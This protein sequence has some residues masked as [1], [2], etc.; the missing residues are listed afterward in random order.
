ML[1][2]LAH[3]LVTALTVPLMP[4]IRTDFDLDYTQAGL[5]ISA[6]TLSSGICQLPAG[7]LADR[8]GPRILITVG[9][10]GV[11]LAG[12]LVGLSQTYIVML[13]FFVLM[14]VASGGY[15]PSAPPLILKLVNPE[16]QGRAL[17]L[18]LIGG[19]AS[20]FLAPLIGAAIA[21]AWSWRGAYIGLAVPV[22]IFGIVLY[23]LLGRRVD[24]KTTGHTVTDIHDKS[25]LTPGRW[26]HLAALI[27]LSSF[28]IAMTFSIFAFIPLFIVDNFH[29]S[30]QTAATFL[31]IGYSAGL[32]AGPLGGYLSDRFGRIPVILI[33]CLMSG[34]A[35]YL[36]NLAPYGLGLGATIVLIHMLMAMRM[37][38]SE[39]YIMEQAPVR[40]R[41]T[42]LGI[43]FLS[44]MEGGGILTPVM[45]SL[46]DRFGFHSS[47][48]IAAAALLVVTLGCSVLLWRTRDRPSPD[49]KA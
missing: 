11:A 18:H 42:I 45:G 26:C 27:I 22:I 13:L 29:A 33:V 24:T 36:L 19:S 32:W 17:G 37:P 46:I 20:F 4:F 34:P 5:L 30:E 9:I 38:A 16:K 43:Y 3:H 6:F 10:S 2:H 40:Y 15:H 41:S 28:T 44:G 35:I 25:S 7:W 1:A 8:I 39:A 14:G 23:V 48:A 12:L 47:F 21:A 49:R 31:A